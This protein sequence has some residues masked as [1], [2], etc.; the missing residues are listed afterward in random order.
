MMSV[1]KKTAIKIRLFSVIDFEMPVFSL[2]TFESE[3]VS[4]SI[5]SN[6]LW[7]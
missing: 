4:W 1:Q 3:S 5:V 7:L 6:S 2:S